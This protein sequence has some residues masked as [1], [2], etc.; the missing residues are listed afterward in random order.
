MT[1]AR[2]A[3]AVHRGIPGADGAVQGREQED[4]FARFTV[5][6]YRKIVRVGLMFPT[7]PVGMPGVP[8]ALFDAGGIVTKR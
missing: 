7:V 8:S 3:D 4:R 1:C 6:H 2:A 5:F